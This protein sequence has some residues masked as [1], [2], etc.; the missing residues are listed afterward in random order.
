MSKRDV[1]LVAG[2]AF[3]LLAILAA[4]QVVGSTVHARWAAP[5]TGV[6]ER[7]APTPVP[8]PV[9]KAAPGSL[10]R[11]GGPRNELY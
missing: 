1:T 3:A 8:V 4:A 10:G 2:R 5:A 9:W 7:C 11:L 6:A